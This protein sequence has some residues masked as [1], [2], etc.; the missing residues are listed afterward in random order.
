MS[1]KWEQ[2]D[3]EKLEKQAITTS[4]WDKWDEN[5]KSTNDFMNKS[6]ALKNLTSYDDEDGYEDEENNQKD[7][8]QNDDDIDGKPMDEDE[9]SDDKSLPQI[10][11]RSIETFYDE[12]KR[13]FLRE[14]EVRNLNISRLFKNFIP[15]FLMK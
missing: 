8:D 11:N 4:K 7:N 13:K 2:V 12:E 1:S 5:E 10:T 6:E 15:A 3:P 9:E 14:I